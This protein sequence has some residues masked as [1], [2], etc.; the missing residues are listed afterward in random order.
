MVVVLLVPASAPYT[1]VSRSAGQRDDIST[2]G[3][4]VA[5]VDCR[6]IGGARGHRGALRGRARGVDGGACGG[7]R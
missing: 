5:A 1:R 3:K 7:A 6:A 2:S 4:L